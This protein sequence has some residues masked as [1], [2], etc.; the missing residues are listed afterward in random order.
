MSSEFLQVFN[1]RMSGVLR[2]QQLESIWQN[3]NADQGWYLYETNASLPAEPI[4]AAA[5]KSAIKEIDAFL[6]QQHDED[7]CGVVYTDDINAPSLLKIYHPKKM[8]TSCGSG[9]ATV[10]PKWTLSK[11]APVDLLEWSLEKD[12]KP[13]WWKQM[14]KK[15]A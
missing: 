6:H 5:L 12:Q 8:G 14:L 4:D 10:L 13:A 15:R 2:W 11:M 9:S 7:Y 1:G 3:L